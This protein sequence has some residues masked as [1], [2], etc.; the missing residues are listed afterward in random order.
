MLL[1]LMTL[2]LSPGYLPRVHPIGPRPV[3]G[4]YRAL[5]YAPI[6][7]EPFHLR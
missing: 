1:L 7:P 6:G 3:A 2:L 4:D 5:H